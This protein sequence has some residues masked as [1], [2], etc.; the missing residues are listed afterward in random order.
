MDKKTIVGLVVVIALIILEIVVSILSFNS[1]TI[2]VPIAESE[3]V[4]DNTSSTIP[5]LD[6]ISSIVG[7]PAKVV[8]L[9]VSLLLLLIIQ[10]WIYSSTG[11]LTLTAVVG[12]PLFFILRFFGFM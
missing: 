12:V 8:S 7:I 5:M 3:V 2:K 4:T 6:S 11:S 10:I 9:I 1:Y